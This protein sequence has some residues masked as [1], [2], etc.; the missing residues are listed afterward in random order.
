VTAEPGSQVGQSP[1]ALLQ[2]IQAMRGGVN[3]MER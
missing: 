3:N 1:A 2:T